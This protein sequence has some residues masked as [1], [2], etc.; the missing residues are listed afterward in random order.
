[1]RLQT[2]LLSHPQGRPTSRVHLLTALAILIVV[3]LLGSAASLAE[4]RP[5]SSAT[6]VRATNSAA[7]HAKTARGHAPRH[8][9]HT[10]R[11][12][13]SKLA[14][15]S[16]H[17]AKSPAPAPPPAIPPA[18]PPAPAPAPT[19]PAPTEAPAQGTGS[20][21][22]P[23][24]SVTCDLLAAP[25]GSDSSGNGTVARPYQ[26]VA[27]LD[28]ALQPGQTG[29]LR[30]GT[31]GSVDTWHK[32]I[33]DGSPSARITITAYPGETPTIVGWVDLEASYTTLSALHIDGSNTF[34][35]KSAD[36]VC[37][38]PHT[39]SQAL[40][41]VGTGDVF[42]RNDFYQS[43]AALRGNGIGVGFW[44]HADNTTVR[45]NRIHD[46]GQCTQHDHLIYLASG[47]NVQIYDNWMYNDH[48][49]FGVTAYPRPTNARIF[50][51]VIT[52]AGAG[53]NFGDTGTSAT[54]GNEAWHNVATNEFRV[55]A[56]QGG[57]LQGVLVMCS[58]LD[59]SSTGNEV[60]ENDSFENPDGIS[61][62][63]SH[64]SATRISLSGNISA[65]PRF[66]NPA[67]NDYSV[68]PS[69]PVA[70]WGLWNGA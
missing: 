50:S 59:A 57:T 20:Q 55:P 11:R 36:S 6:H 58:D 56:D 10:L 67:A 39:V 65:D 35:N 32:L 40:D 53:L 31:Y 52:N 69:S 64:L 18:T 49:G 37:P 5:S 4:A 29:C 63:N 9:R 13:S 47:D 14:L 38:S 34:Y 70:S 21:P 66:V 22:A 28:H 48:N 30:G 19:P 45:Y 2:M 25:S 54:M 68:P 8:R 44:G 46:V 1:M 62:V 41:L 26:S 7:R 17:H 3:G 12:R 61:A 27:V 15:H 16:T 60:F 24:L 42:E 51:N 23:P 33:K 43:V